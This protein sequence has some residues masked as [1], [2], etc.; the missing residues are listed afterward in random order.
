MLTGCAPRTGWWQ[1]KQQIHNMVHVEIWMGDGQKTLGARN[2]RGVVE[3]HDCYQF[4]SKGYGDMKYHFRSLETWLD[5]VCVRYVQPGAVRCGSECRLYTALTI[6]RVAATAGSTNGVGR[7]TMYRESTPSS[8]RTSRRRLMRVLG[9][10]MTWRTS[11][12]L[13]C[14]VPR[15]AGASFPHHAS[16]HRHHLATRRAPINYGVEYHQCTTLLAC[17]AMISSCQKTCKVAPPGPVMS[18]TPPDRLAST[19]V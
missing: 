3:I 16:F 2:Q 14:F 19:T 1:R 13:P 12:G 11:E 15:C 6:D 8:P 7:V 9:T 18:A 17:C 5:G 10:C 4:V